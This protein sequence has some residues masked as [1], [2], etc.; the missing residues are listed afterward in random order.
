MF[1]VFL[2]KLTCCAITHH[3][4]L[5]GMSCSLKPSVFIRLLHEKSW[6]K[7]SHALI[8][9]KTLFNSE[10]ALLFKLWAYSVGDYCILSTV[11]SQ[12]KRGFQRADPKQSSLIEQEPA[13]HNCKH[14]VVPFHSPRVCL[15]FCK[16]FPMQ[17]ITGTAYTPA[18][19]S[20]SHPRWITQF[21]TRQ[22]SN[23]KKRKIMTNYS[24]CCHPL[25]L[26]VSH[27]S[28]RFWISHSTDHMP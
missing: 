7:P 13:V 6:A 4:H 8:Y 21:Q 25:C 3:S 26:R 2:K 11:Q 23:I 17:F 14:P 27:F 5:H 24:L 18:N 20:F 9:L 19:S 10:F 15:C 22:G 16:W 1:T 12:W 28:V